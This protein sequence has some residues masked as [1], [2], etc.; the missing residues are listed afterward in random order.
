MYRLFDIIY[1]LTMIDVHI[2][3]EKLLIC[4]KM[5]Y[6]NVANVAFM[7]LVQITFHHAYLYM[8]LLFTVT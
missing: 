4:S 3:K 5:R 7:K 8:Y 2:P 1:R 6:I